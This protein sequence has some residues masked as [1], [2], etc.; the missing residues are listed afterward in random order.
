MLKTCHRSSGSAIINPDSAWR[1]AHVR[2]FI[3]LDERSIRV[4]EFHK[5]KERLKAHT[6][7]NLGKELAESV[8][9]VTDAREV[10]LR[11]KETTE[12]RAILSAGK[13]VTKVGVRD[14]LN[15]M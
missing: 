9:P 10:K 2:G 11:Q 5:I 14:I 15:V 12:G 1:Y 4:L 13:D 3:S 7:T 6:A 8:M